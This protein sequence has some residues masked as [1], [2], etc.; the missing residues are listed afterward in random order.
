M[1]LPA[2]VH[3]LR[4]VGLRSAVQIKNLVLLQPQKIN[5]YYA[6]QADI[7]HG[8]WLLTLE[9]EDPAKKSHSS[10][11][12]MSSGD[13]V[14]SPREDGVTIY[15]TLVWG[16]GGEWAEWEFEVPQ[17]GYY[18]IGFRY[19]QNQKHNMCTYR[20]IEINGVVP[21][22]ELLTYPFDYDF[23][24]QSTWLNT[25]N[26][27]PILVYLSEG[28][29]TIRLTAVNEPIQPT[30]ETIL[31]VIRQ[32]RAISLTITMATG[33]TEDRY[34][35]WNIHEQI[36]DIEERIMENAQQLRNEYE[37]LRAL[38]DKAPDA[39]SN[40]LVSAEQ[41]EKLVERPEL[42][43][44]R[45]KQLAIDSGS[46][47]EV[48]GNTI[49]A[50][51]DEYLQ[52]DQIFIASVGHP[53]PHGKSGV[54]DRSLVTV[55][56]FV[57]SFSRNYNAVGKD[58][59]DALQ[60]WVARG[61]DFVSLMQQLTDQEFTP[62]TGI[63]V[64]FSLMPQPEQ[65][66]IL[67]NSNGTPP[68]LATSVWYTIPVN[69]ASRGALVD[70][71]QFPDYKT[72]AQRFHPGGLVS[73]TY[74]D[75][76]YALPETQNFWVL[77]YRKD[78]MEE[79]AVELPDTWDDV[80]DLLPT[81]QEKGMNFYNPVSA[82]TGIKAIFVMAPFFFQEGAELFS[83][84]GLRTGLSTPQALAGFRRLTDL[85]N[86]YSLDDFVAWF[87]QN[88]RSGDIPIGVSDYN[89]FVQLKAAA[90]ELEGLW[91]IRPLPGVKRDD[92][93]IA[94]WA[95]GAAQ[96][97]IMFNQSTKQDQA[98][99]WLK[100]WTSA[101]TQARFGNELEAMFGVSYRWNTANMEAVRQ[102]PWTL[103]ELAALEEQWRWLKDVPQVPG[104]YILER[105]LSFAWNRVVIGTATGNQ[106]PRQALQEAD[107]NVRRE[108]LRKQLEFGLID[109]NEQPLVEFRIPIITE[110]WDWQKEGQ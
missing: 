20:R 88:F 74:L 5:P 30:I 31:D 8:D 1:V 78:I 106:N 4:L 109:E 59:E 37:R 55:K 89:T 15:N 98:W 14:V 21:Y 85:Y 9:A 29:N 44:L 77:F 53:L 52:L 57:S 13:P 18:Q 87:F 22:E 33:Y 93:E 3:T 80:V 99:E 51:Q 38:G 84:D 100:W 90:P 92:G 39:A 49:L 2:G 64:S 108:L 47:T 97:A 23:N 107:R 19:R 76:V 110:P 60:I 34:R 72:I 26:D 104:G 25:G 86:V 16:R 50:L 66:L 69:L 91:G 63:P 28:L 82:G 12:V 58:D 71:T 95:P 103:E 35:D 96:S 70:L 10:V 68:D 43:P 75:G 94:R 45:Y 73:Y 7:V 81:L 24:W 27:E 11:M 101:E 41:L 67:A 46:I 42:I 62:K 102:M 61:R 40:L 54:L 36:P 17:S 48:I 79:L 6:P 105:E 56:N 83:Q 32:L 65:Q